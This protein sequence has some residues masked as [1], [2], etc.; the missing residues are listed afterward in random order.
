LFTFS[1]SFSKITFSQTLEFY[2]EK[3]YPLILLSAFDLILCLCVLAFLS[4]WGL[5][6][7]CTKTHGDAVSLLGTYIEVPMGTQAYKKVLCDG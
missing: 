4:R 1:I 5:K 2:R 7:K 3:S 6:P